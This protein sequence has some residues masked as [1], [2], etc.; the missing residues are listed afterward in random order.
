MKRIVIALTMVVL[1]QSTVLLAGELG[2]A[3]PKEPRCS[4]KQPLYFRIAF[5]QK[6]NAPMLGV[7]DE[8]GGSGAG[9]DTVYL[10]ENMDND[11]TNDGPKKFRPA[12]R[13]SS[14]GGKF[15]PEFQFNGPLGP[16][17]RGVYTVTIYTL[18]NTKTR[19][20]SRVQEHFIF[21]RLAAMGWNYF[22][23]NGKMTLYPTLSEALKGAPL[24]L[25]GRCQWDISAQAKG[26][27]TVISA[28]L[29]DENGGTLRSLS[30]QGQKDL[31]PSLTLLQNGKVITEKKLEFG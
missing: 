18:G 20:A 4:S 13:P 21:W 7:I 1:W 12:Q 14:S 26:N 23:I 19:T 17:A 5:Q 30:A 15:E 24:C 11:L 8:S 3:P 2:A 31:K 9:Y 27:E 29:K 10:D 28:G 25:G 22:F 16:K 6:D